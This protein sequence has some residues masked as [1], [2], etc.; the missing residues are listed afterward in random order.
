MFF[1]KKK[2]L[3]LQNMILQKNTAK[4]YLKNFRLNV[5]DPTLDYEKDKEIYEFPTFRLSPNIFDI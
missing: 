5:S 2:E 3:F 4:F 1:L